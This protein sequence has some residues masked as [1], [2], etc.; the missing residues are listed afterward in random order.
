MLNTLAWWHNYHT[1]W[2]LTPEWDNKETAKEKEEEV[3][4]DTERWSTKC[5]VCADA[6]YGD[7]SRNLS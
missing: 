6:T 3:E 5:K 4:L 2:N 7:D 1:I